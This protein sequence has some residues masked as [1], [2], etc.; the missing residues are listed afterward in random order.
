VYVRDR[1][2]EFDGEFHACM[3]RNFID[4]RR[5]SANHPQ[6]TQADGLAKRCVQTI[7]RS[8]RRYIE[9]QKT[10]TTWDEHLP[11]LQLG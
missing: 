5:T 6:A 9:D 1:G 2:T 3:E 10:L 11:Y 4:H 8:V 7:K